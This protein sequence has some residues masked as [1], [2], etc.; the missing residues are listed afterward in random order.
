MTAVDPRLLLEVL[1]QSRWI[2]AQLA[3]AK[4]ALEQGTP[5][6]SV[7]RSLYEEGRLTLTKA[8]ET[9]ASLATAPLESLLTVRTKTGSAENPITKLFPAAITE[10]QFVEALD[11]LCAK[12]RSVQYRD[13]RKDGHTLVDFTLTEGDDEIPVNVK[14]AGTRFENAATLVGLSPDDCIPIPAYKAHDAVEKVPNLLY[15]VC[16]N[17][18]LLAKIRDELLSLLTP[19]E[20]HV[21]DVLNAYGGTLIR[22]AEDHF[23]YGMVSRYWDRFSTHMQLPDFRVVSA[24]KAIRVLQTIP[25]RTPG[26]GLRA[27]GTGASAEVNVHL[28]VKEETKSWSTIDERIV[29]RGLAD[30]V[31]AVNRKR[32]EIVFDPEI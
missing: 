20:G 26:I 10:R 4:T 28:S 3:R 29:N 11:V 13:D 1:P 30:I 18:G 15:A 9:V 6:D 19:A 16:V 5:P 24:R 25:R 27:W 17:Y 2:G 21:W 8:K 22:D 12:R 23:I 32:T 7:A 31:Q 14:N